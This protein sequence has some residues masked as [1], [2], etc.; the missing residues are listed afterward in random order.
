METSPAKSK[1]KSALTK[2]TS[3]KS[4]PTKPTESEGTVLKKSS[5]PTLSQSGKIDY[6]ISTNSNGVIHIGLT[7]NSGSGYFSK[8]KQPVKEI[9]TAL[10]QFQA[11][12]EITSLALKDLYPGSSINSWS[13]MMSVLLGL[14]L[15]VPLEK[16]GRRYQ[17]N[18]PEAFLKSLEKLKASKAQHSVPAKGKPNAKVKPASRMLKSKATPATG[19]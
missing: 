12:H 17:L 10:E 11:K 7:G 9:I 16:N 4:T 5:C 3:A 19:K 8:A 13:F 1:R 15:I 6:E 14:G 2:S 18:N